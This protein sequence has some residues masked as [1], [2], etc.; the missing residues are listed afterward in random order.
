MSRAGRRSPATDR[1]TVSSPASM[2]VPRTLSCRACGAPPA[3]KDLDHVRGVVVCRYCR[4]VTPLPSHEPGLSRGEMGVP[5]GVQVEDDGVRL[6]I[7]RRWF[8]PV[9]LFFLVFLPF[10]FGGLVF[11]Y[12]MAGRMGAPPFFLVFPLLHVA[13]GVVL[14]YWTA[15]MLFNSTTVEADPAG[16]V[17]VRS[18]PVPWRRRVEIPAEEIAQVFTTEKR[19]RQEDGPEQ[20][21]YAV[22]VLTRDGARVPLVRGMIQELEHALFLEQALETRLGLPDRR[23]AGEVPRN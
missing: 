3:A 22:E 1:E 5:R 2:S 4:A 19:Y 7:R 18:G 14:A 6:W 10:W 15:A 17:T 20:R 9:H 11:W 12:G 16:S 8:S 23:V 13:V 21:L